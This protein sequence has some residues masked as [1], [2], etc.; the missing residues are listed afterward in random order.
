MDG[1]AHVVRSTEHPFPVPVAA[2]VESGSTCTTLLAGTATAPLL[3]KARPPDPAQEARR[4]SY[5]ALS[6]PPEGG[7]D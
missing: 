2:T 1:T 3:R 6:C 7:L 5:T 4:W